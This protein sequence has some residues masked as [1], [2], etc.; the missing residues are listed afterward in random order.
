MC[1]FV[2]WPRRTFQF[3]KGTIRTLVFHLVK[4]LSTLFQFHKGTIRTD[5]TPLP[6]QKSRNFNSIKVRLE[7]AEARRAKANGATFQFH[8]GTIRTFKECLPG[9]KFKLF[10]FHKGTIRTLSKFW[11]NFTCVYFNSIKVR[12]EPVSVRAVA[13]FQL[14]QFHKGTI[15]TGAEF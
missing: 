6:I 2:I 9:D 5:A 4:P 13:Y 3:H 8:K 11:T 10:Q 7:R 14:F 15:R 12:L 1:H